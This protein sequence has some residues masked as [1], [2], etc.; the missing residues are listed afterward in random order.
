MW[1]WRTRRERQDADLRAELQTHLELEAEDQRDR[2]LDPHQAR[3]AARRAFGNFAVVREEVQDVWRWATVE[4]FVQDVRYA[5][6][7][8]RRSPGFAVAAVF[9]LA[10]G[11]GVNAGIFSFAD[12]VVFRPLPIQDPGSL[13]VI[14]STSPENPF[15]GESYPDF[16][17]LRE[18]NR[19]FSALIAHRLWVFPFAKSPDAVP[20][21]RMSMKVSRDFFQ[22]LGV[23]PVL[24]RAF[25]PEETEV[26][27]RD[28]VVVL[29]YGFWVSEFA[30]DPHAIGRV[31]QIGQI[32]VT[33]VGVAPASFTGMDPIIQPFM[34]VPA[35]LG[36]KLNQDPAKPAASVLRRRDELGFVVRGRLREGV[37]RAQAQADVAALARALEEEFPN[38][39]RRRSA[40][41]RTE[42]ELR[43]EQAPGLLPIMVLLLGL[44]GLVLAIVCANVAN[45]FL[46]RARARSREIAIRL[47][48]GAG[49]FRLIRQLLTESAVIGFAG[50]V[51][52]LA[53]AFGVVR[54]LQSIR[55]PTDTPMAIAAQV[56]VRLLE[57]SAAAALIS[58]LAFGVV[59]AWQAAR[60]DLVSALKRSDASSRRRRILGRQALVVGQI[61]VSLVLLVA[62]GL[63]LDG[64]RRMLVLDTGFRTDHVLMMEFDPGTI[65]Y[66]G[67]QTRD[68]YDQLVARTRALPVVQSAGLSR[69]IPF[70]PSFSEELLVPEGY[71]LPAGQ[72]GVRTSTN[73]VGDGYFATLGIAIVSGRAFGR[74][75]TADSPPS[76]IVNETFATTYWPG[77]NPIGKRVRLGSGGGWS[78]V[79]GVARTTKYLQ[80]TERPQPYVYLPL[81]QHRIN[82]LTL[83]IH[84]AGD[85]LAAADPV[86]SIVRSLDATLPIANT[87]TMQ[88]LYEDGALG[89][90]RL[91][92]ELVA[93]MGLLGL[94][95][96]LVGIYAVVSY[97]VRRRMREFGVRLSIGAS[98][99]DILRLVLKEG[100]VLA[101]IGVL[102][103]MLLSLPVQRAL[104]TALAGLGPLD[105][106]TL[107]LVPIGLIVVAL[108]ACLG[109]A[110]RASRVDPCL[111]LRLD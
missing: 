18:R 33:I 48:I 88:T 36:E 27:G 16:K 54:Y 57:F 91:I 62:A 35:P 47:A 24:G 50:G 59:P 46:S 21:M 73:T 99:A 66:S 53:L 1:P 42:L 4:Q 68:F 93:T 110:W 22:T 92:L 86:R 40:A 101:G 85:P 38:T 70:R 44:S 49:Q 28:A 107:A 20:Q 104:G 7:T 98:Q 77:Q 109:P 3:A 100:L 25:L 69:A 6:V 84:T 71:Q 26:P 94:C 29:S 37:S 102:F 52:G 30:S 95:L 39:N 67:Q 32:P 58:A 61:A 60:T 56:D 13:V 64:F 72:E 14:R 34:F 79:V 74:E 78:E 45:L 9:S 12:A 106:T 76:A 63:M 83:L 51:A 105:T 108:A 82:R 103:G 89:I 87:R 23:E 111:V 31:I 19:S 97:S 2:G 75:D 96:A 55:I 15:S 43:G 90:Q 8:M 80:I 17:D 10:L 5:L 41:V 11:I 65:G 81:E